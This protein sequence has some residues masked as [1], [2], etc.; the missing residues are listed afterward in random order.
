MTA[1][2]T[3]AMAQQPNLHGSTVSRTLRREISEGPLAPKSEGPTAT[4]SEVPLNLRIEG[5]PATM[6]EGPLATLQE[7]Y[8]ARHQ[9]SRSSPRQVDL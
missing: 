5:P 2:L 6:S 9:H 8:E 1:T 7:G 4:R 3:G